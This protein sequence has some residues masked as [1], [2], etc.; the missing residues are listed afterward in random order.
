M[1]TLVCLGDSLTGPTPGELY[2]DKYLKWS[3]LLQIGFDAV[4]GGS[5]VRV[6]NQGKAGEGS[7]GL[8]AA[9]DERLIDHRPDVVVLMIGANNFG[10]CTDLPAALAAFKTD[11]TTI[12]QRAQQAGIKVL[13]MQ[14]PKPVAECME[15]VWTH[16]D[17]G[18]PVIAEVAA[19]T[20]VPLLDLR[21]AFGE[22]AKTCSLASLVSPV[23]GV[24]LNPGGE[25]VV[26]STVL[27]KL[28]MLGWPVAWPDLK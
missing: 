11:L 4:F 3:N 24:H 16:G 28:R 20:G 25:I 21:R 13:L 23:D 27:A 8:L 9:L 26:G 14:Y 15:K 6:L 2:L 7:P 5:A 19:E 18:N 17:A 22:A 1:K 12:V 10:K